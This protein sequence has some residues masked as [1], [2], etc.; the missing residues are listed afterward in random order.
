MPRQ[1]SGK[2]KSSA[3]PPPL[4]DLAGKSCT[5]RNAKTEPLVTPPPNIQKYHGSSCCFTT[6]SL[7]TLLQVGSPHKTSFAYRRRAH[8]ISLNGVPQ[9]RP[10]H[11]RSSPPSPSRKKR[12]T[13]AHRPS[14]RNQRKVSSTAEGVSLQV[15]ARDD[16]LFLFCYLLS[17][18]VWIRKTKK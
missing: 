18:W 4:H 9:P 17:P 13:N 6:A 15:I 12:T 5:H 1:N 14:E 10:V 3:S 8:D 7:S 2:N 11:A 16:G